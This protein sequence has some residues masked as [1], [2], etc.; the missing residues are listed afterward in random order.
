MNKYEE[1]YEELFSIGVSNYF[2]SLNE[3]PRCY[4]QAKVHR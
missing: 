2:D 3:I 4:E 1:K